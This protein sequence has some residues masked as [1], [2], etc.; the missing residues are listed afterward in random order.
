MKIDHM[1]S[2]KAYFRKEIWSK[3]MKIDHTNSRRVKY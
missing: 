1:N 2:R 3:M